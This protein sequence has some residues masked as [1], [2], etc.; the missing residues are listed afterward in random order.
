MQEMETAKITSMH[1]HTLTGRHLINGQWVQSGNDPFNAS[2]P[3]TGAPLEPVFHKATNAEV[4]MALQAAEAAFV[5]TRDLSPMRW[6]ELLDAIAQR[7]MDLGDPLLHR[8]NTETGLP[9]QRLIA[10]RGRTCGQ[11]NLFAN[12]VREGSWV[13]AVIDT[14][15]PQ[16]QPVPKPD[17]R[18]MLRAIGPV[19]VF[20]ASNFPFAFGA[21]GGD[22]ASAI[23]AGNPVVVKAHTAHPGTNE[24]FSAAVLAALNDCHMPLGLFAMLQGPGTT[25]GTALVKHPATQAVGF[26]GS[27]HAGRLLFDLAAAR[28][29]PI[30]VYAEMG[31]LNPL[32]ILPGA[33]AERSEKIAIGLAQSITLGVGQF[34]TKPGLILV[35]DGPD[36]TTFIG[37]LIQQLV[38]VPP[39]TMLDK[40]MQHDFCEVTTR[41]TKIPGVKAHLVNQPSGF[42]NMAP[43][44]FEVDS[45]IWRQQPSLHE[46]AFGPATIVIRC[47]DTTDLC[48]TIAAAGGN[49]TGTLHVGATDHSND[50]R[51]IASFIEQHV[52][53]VIFD[54]FPTGVEVCHAMVH[55]GPY[56]ATTIPLATSV[57]TLAILRFA[58]PIAYQNFPDTFLPPALQNA[59]PLN[60]TRRVNGVLTHEPIP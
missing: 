39:A 48:T 23:A 3:V 12:L 56:P 31:S 19:A 40:K 14:A 5:Q 25:V 47:H 37:Q 38:A 15:N 29:S 49:L 7:I 20:G 8:A 46:E 10:E 52:G 16:R 41:F 55:A 21:C 28:P 60:I 34:C 59:N 13:D 36:T 53:R 22:T 57:G 44:L 32:I 11:L 30:P 58:R 2:T 51:T 27:R 54:G 18:R 45:T 26:T 35:L 33:L 43:L 9:L 6:A 42:A 4:D 24:L 17:V 50:V 1:T